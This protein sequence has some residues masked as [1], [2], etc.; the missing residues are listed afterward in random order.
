MFVYCL[1]QSDVLFGAEYCV[2]H[3]CSK[4]MCFMVL[5]IVFDV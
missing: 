2:L 3:V 1:L 5:S 4:W